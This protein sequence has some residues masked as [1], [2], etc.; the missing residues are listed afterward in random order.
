[1]EILTNEKM[2]EYR[3]GIKMS[4]GVASVIAAVGAFILGIIDG[5]SN[6]KKCN[7]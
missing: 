5:V 7:K 3:G 6:P 4:I 2:L 1:M